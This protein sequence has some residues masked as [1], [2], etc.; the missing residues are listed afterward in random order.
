MLIYLI[1]A[2]LKYSFQGEGQDGNNN[3]HTGELT[4]GLRLQNVRIGNSNFLFP[5]A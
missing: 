1:R 4:H 3:E 2:F 5:I